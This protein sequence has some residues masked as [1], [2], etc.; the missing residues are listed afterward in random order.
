VSWWRS[1][2]ISRSLAA[3]P[4]A[5][6]TSACMER[7]TARYA[8]FDGTRDGLRRVDR[9]RSVPSCRPTRT[10]RPQVTSEFAHPSPSPGMDRP[11][12]RATKRRNA[13]VVWLESVTAPV[14]SLETTRRAALHGRA[15]EC[16]AIDP[17]RRRQR[18]VPPHDR[19]AAGWLAH[20]A[21]AL[22]FLARS[23]VRSSS[24][25]IS[26]SGAS[27]NAARCHSRRSA[28]GSPRR[29]STRA[30]WTACRWGRFAPW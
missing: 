24:S 6:S 30:R 20:A 9:G 25:A 18:V 13:S 21:C 23:A 3:S 22:R 15:P 11:A 8:G 27:I 7:H 19:V 1:T 16:A 10:S 17:P 29:V 12:A 26:S 2:R 14:L 28:L 5:S 4:R